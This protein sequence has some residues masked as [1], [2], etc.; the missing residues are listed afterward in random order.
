VEVARA[1]E[2]VAIRSSAAELDEDPFD[3]EMEAIK[4]FIKALQL[5]G[6][7]SAAVSEA[8]GIL[9]AIVAIAEGRLLPPHYNR[10]VGRRKEGMSYH[11]V[12]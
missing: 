10:W 8:A 3:F 1:L 11:H 7:Q 5:G 12:F 9:R 6:S 2:Y 4:V